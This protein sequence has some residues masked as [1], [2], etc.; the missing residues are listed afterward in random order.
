MADNRYG[1]FKYGTSN[2]YGASSLSEGLGWAIEVDWDGDGLFDGENEAFYLMTAPRITRG[3]RTMLRPSGQ[4]FESV[5]TGSA[6]FQLS[7]HDGRY[8]AW[9]TSSPLY[10]NVESGKDVRIRVLDRSTGDVYARF[11]GVISNIDPVG[12]G[13]DAY[14]VISADDTLRVLRDVE[15]T[16]QRPYPDGQF[17]PAPAPIND[18]ID[19][20]LDEM[21]WPTR[22]GREIETSGYGIRYWYSSGDRSVATEIEDIA[23]SFFGYFFIDNT[24]KAKFIN[25]FGNATSVISI[26]QD[27]ML[28]DIGN[29]QPW[30]IR[31]QVVKIRFH[32]RKKLSTAYVWQPL[33]TDPPIHP[34]ESRDLF[35]SYTHDG[36]QVYLEVYADNFVLGF[37]RDPIVYESPGSIVGSVTR[38][39]YGTKAFIS[40]PADVFSPSVTY[41]LRP[42]DVTDDSVGGDLDTAQ[43]IAIRGNISWTER[44][45][46]I[47]S[48]RNPSSIENP[49]SLVLD[50]LWYQDRNQA[51]E[52]VD[53]YKV[54]ISELHKTPIIQIENRFEQQFTPDLFD[55]IT[56]DIPKLG[57][58]EEEFRVGAIEEEPIGDTTQAVRTTFYLEPFLQPN[59]DAG[60]W[61]SGEWG[62]SEWGW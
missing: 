12:Y 4:G 25:N 3:R 50:S 39:N 21:Q 1:L 38:T 32:V 35:V 18:C 5:R 54:F 30:T 40:I 11:Y 20:L 6:S 47:S 31:R 28:K 57:I 53:N 29:P 8:D 24:G 43:Y 10:P 36:Y 19:E 37:S 33:E 34:G 23:L 9:N 26:A 49:R 51:Y 41:Y 60:K 62:T 27:E 45:D 17:S 7:N 58:N 55:V 13:S 46:T 56:V 61:G 42:G 52:F 14:V 22:W 16:A 2:K 59:P 44:A 48:P 15:V